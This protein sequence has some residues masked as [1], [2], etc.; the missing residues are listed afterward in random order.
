[1]L[2]HTYIFYFLYLLAC[3]IAVFLMLA[4]LLCDII[5]SLKK[6]IVKS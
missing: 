6:L 2:K 4:S 3:T 5:A 1:M